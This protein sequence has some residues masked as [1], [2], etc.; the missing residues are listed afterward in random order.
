MQDQ[1]AFLPSTSIHQPT[2][3][4]PSFLEQVVWV[5]AWALIV[6]KCLLLILGLKRFFS[7]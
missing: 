5:T 7:H 1:G 3:F 2:F 4:L 6:S